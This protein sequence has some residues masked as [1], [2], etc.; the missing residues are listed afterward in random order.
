[1]LF[2]FA[3]G[4][5]TV[6]VPVNEGEL[7]FAFKAKS[8]FK[9]VKLAVFAAIEVVADVML[10]VFE[11]TVL[12]IE[13]VFEN[14]VLILEVFEATVFVNEVILAV[15]ATIL[16]VAEVILAVLLATV[17]VN[18][19]I[20][21]VFEAT[22]LVNEVILAAL[23]VTLVSNAVKLFVLVVKSERNV[24]KSLF[25]EVILAVFEAIELNADVILEVLDAIDVGS[26]A[27][28][29]ELTPPT[30]LTVGNA[31]VPPKSFV[32]CILPFVEASASGVAAEVTKEDTNAVVAIC[33][34]LVPAVAVGAVGTPVNVGEAIFAFSAMLFVLVVIL[35]V[36]EIT[37]VSNAAISF[38]LVVILNVLEAINVGKVLIVDELIPPTVLTVG[39]DA[40]PPKSFVN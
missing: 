26:V 12:D 29:D 39:A 15:F 11:E 30:E 16:F 28:V 13:V 37:L 5:G 38:V 6:G 17:F 1:L 19:V 7:I 25:V 24:A 2:E 3:A 35:A 27:M 18:E 31:A 21:E 14:M 10:A 4:A 20:L 34:V 8:A 9:E 33:V 23:D 36:L 22:V 32:N 40:V